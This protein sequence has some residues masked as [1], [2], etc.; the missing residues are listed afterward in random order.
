MSHS[1]LQPE[2][3]KILCALAQETRLE[4]FRLLSASGEQGM[5]AGDIAKALDVPHNTLSTHL[6]ILRQAGLIT[7]K[8]DGRNVTYY[9]APS[10]LEAMIAFLLEDCCGAMPHKCFPFSPPSDNGK[11]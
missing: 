8:R 5:G 11:P 9:M 1:G 3:L 10:S 4:A 2:A 6:A 7:S